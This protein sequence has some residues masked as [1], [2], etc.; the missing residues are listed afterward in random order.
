M[1]YNTG[2]MVGD[3]EDQD[4]VMVARR[5]GIYIGPGCSNISLSNNT[6]VCALPD[7]F[8]LCATE[9]FDPNALS[10]VFGMHCVAIHDPIAFFQH[11]TAQLT[12]IHDIT[13]ATLGRIIYKDRFYTGLEQP[14]G[15]MGFVKPP[16]RYSDQNEFRL[17]WTVRRNAPIS[18]FEL[19]VPTVSSLCTRVA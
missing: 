15:L 19:N 13:E 16:D 14:P 18:P 9:R 4:F 17:L 6:S 10:E 5:A 12:R 8:V 11:V 1:R 2:H 3:S 7:A